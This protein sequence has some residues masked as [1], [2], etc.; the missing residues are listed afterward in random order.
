FAQAYSENIFSGGWD[1]IANANQLTIGLTT[2]WFDADSG[3]ERLSLSAAQRVYFS[4]QKVSL[5]PTD[6]LRTD[7]K[8]DYLVGASAALTD[9]FNLRFDAQFNPESQDR[10]R[11]VTGFRWQPK[12]LATLSAYYR[13]QRDPAQVS[14]PN[15]IYQP[16]YVDNS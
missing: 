7:T 4:D 15:V 2:R 12:R 13:Y 5:Y 14:E 11:L 9:T 16:G 3:L 10:N 6:K 1:R 8:S